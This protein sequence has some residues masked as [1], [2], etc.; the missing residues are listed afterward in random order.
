[1]S[2]ARGYSRVMVCGFATYAVLVIYLNIQIKEP[3]AALFTTQRHSKESRY[4]MSK[5]KGRLKGVTE[6]CSKI[7]YRYDGKIQNRIF[8]N[9]LLPLKKYNV[10]FC[11]VTK[12]A[13]TFWTRLLVCLERG[14]WKPPY[15]FKPNDGSVKLRDNFNRFPIRKIYKR[16][17][18]TKNFMFSRNPYSRI[19]SFYVDK[20]FSPNPYYWNSL[21]VGIIKRSRGNAT[22]GHDVTFNELVDYIIYT[23]STARDFHTIPINDVCRP[24]IIPYDVIGKMENFEN[25]TSNI[26]KEIGVE[27][28]PYFSENFKKEYTADSIY[29]IAHAYISFRQDSDKCIDRQTGLKRVWR[30]LQIRGIISESVRMPFSSK[31]SQTITLSK[32]LNTIL[33]ARDDSFNEELKDQKATFFKEAYSSVPLDKMMNLQKVY[34]EDFLIFNYESFPKNLFKARRN[35]AKEIFIV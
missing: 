1:M 7:K 13:S 8:T 6:R 29:D 20:L 25:D 16:V 14:L 33:K 31:E 21:G 22:C 11:R 5:Q 26:L 19:F 12:C 2:A 18:D 4:A 15:V 35:T 30:I 24:C 9:S 17:N 34:K 10:T 23:P 3:K 27:S 32:L 28:Y